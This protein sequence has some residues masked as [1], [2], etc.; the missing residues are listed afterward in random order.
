MPKLNRKA[1]LGLYILTVLVGAL[2]VLDTVFSLFGVAAGVVVYVLSALLLAAS[3]FYLIANVR[4]AR[5]K[6]LRAVEAH[7]FTAH[8][9]SDYDYRT[10]V[11]AV[12]GTGLVT[13]FAIF[14]GV[15]G[16]FSRS[17]WY[18]SLALYYLLLSVIRSLILYHVW[19]G[20]KEP[21]TA[22]QKL[23][24]CRFCG[25]LLSAM[26]L[27]LNISVALMVNAGSAKH[28]PGFLIYAVATYTFYKVIMSVVNLCRAKM[29]RNVYVSVLRYIGHADALVS[30]LSLQAAM[31]AAFG[32]EN[33]TAAPVMNA[34][35]GLVVCG[36]VLVLGI[37]IVV[38]S[39]KEIR[40][41]REELR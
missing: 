41:I 10:L 12:P 38:K 9:H 40:S 15:I 2:S 19:R 33:K 3:V 16:I 28:Y 11:T 17:F 34:I 6:V 29:S 22:L 8:L 1:R 7:T 37:Q 27:A 5:A 14:N 32:S 39:Q 31:V 20:K 21:Q 4:L 18:G 36:A 25:M 35:T 30:L 26:T 23:Q 13:G 24:I